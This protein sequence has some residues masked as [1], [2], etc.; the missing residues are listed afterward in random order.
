MQ[1]TAERFRKRAKERLEKVV[2]KEG[3]KHNVWK[4]PAPCCYMRFTNDASYCF[5]D[6][7]IEDER[8]NKRKENNVQFCKVNS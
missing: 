2:D 7:T 1:V 3:I 4:V 6:T 8:L 5:G